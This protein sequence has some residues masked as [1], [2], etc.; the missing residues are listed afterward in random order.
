MDLLLKDLE[1][2][3]AE[4][5]ALPDSGRPLDRQLLDEQLRRGTVLPRIRTTLPARAAGL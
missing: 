1:L 3:L 4:I 2:L 5:S